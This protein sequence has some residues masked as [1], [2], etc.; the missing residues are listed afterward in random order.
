MLIIHNIIEP[1]DPYERQLDFYTQKVIRA[2]KL[3]INQ[4]M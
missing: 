4:V 1:I 2:V 3:F